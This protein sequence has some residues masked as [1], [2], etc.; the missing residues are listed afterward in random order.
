[1]PDSD[2]SPAVDARLVAIFDHDEFGAS[3]DGP[4]IVEAR[5]STAQRLRILEDAM[6]M[7]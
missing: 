1:M 6:R 5:G 4:A 3:S 7:F 2:P